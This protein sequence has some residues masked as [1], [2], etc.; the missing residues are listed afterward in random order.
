MARFRLN[1]KR[2]DYIRGLDGLLEMGNMPAIFQNDYFAAVDLLFEAVG[3]R[4]FKDLVLAAPQHKR[5]LA[6]SRHLH[7]TNDM[8]GR[9]RG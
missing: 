6:H 5:L 8:R 9:G 3:K 7:G 4:H 2:I 1:Q